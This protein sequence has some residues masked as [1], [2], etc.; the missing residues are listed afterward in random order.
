MN[1]SIR[2]KRECRSKIMWNRFTDC[3]RSM[4]L[5]FVTTLKWNFIVALLYLLVALAGSNNVWAAGTGAAAGDLHSLAMKSDGTVW[6]W[7]W[8]EHGQLGDGTNT[9]RKTPV[10]VSDLTDVDAVAGG[11]AHSL[12]LTSDGTVRA[13]GDNSDGEL[14]D[15][16]NTDRKTPVQVSGLTDVAAIAGGGYHSLAVKSDG[17]ATTVWAWGYNHFGQLGDGTNTDRKTPVQVS[18]LTGV[19]VIAGGGYHSLAV[20]SDGGTTT[21]WAWGDNEYGQLGNG[22][23]TASTTPVQV[24]G[25]TDVAAIAGGEYHSLALKSDGTVW[26]WGG[27]D[28]GQLGN[29]T[30]ATS[31]TPVQVTGLSDV[32]AIA[33]GESYSLAVKSDGGTVTV[34][35]WGRNNNGQLGNS[36]TTASTTPVQVS[37]L[38]DIDSIA[39]AAG[40]HHGLAVKSDCT[41]WTWGRNDYGQLGDGTNTESTTPVQATIDLC[42]LSPNPDCKPKK[43]TIVKEPTQLVQGQSGT[44]TVTL[45]G[46][47]G[48]IP[49]GYTVISKVIAGKK[50]LTISP[51]NVVADSNGEA[52]FTMTAAADKK[53]AATVRFKTGKLKKDVKVK[54]KKGV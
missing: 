46:K 27:N 29:G 6:A 42:A 51:E 16:T 19:D 25:L 2:E 1:K 48:C 21:V 32:V 43:M 15:G 35:A 41:V 12:A 44:I 47:K 18:G 49:S 33:G 30:T 53:G 54:V 13:W 28:Y 22:T 31:T 52:E 10:Q 24:S 8:N 5:V 40:G 38:T 23:T 17:G 39:V 34:W 9:N 14:G 26:A 45:K 3:Q 20:K 50:K 36:T 7:G 4:N 11:W 37:G